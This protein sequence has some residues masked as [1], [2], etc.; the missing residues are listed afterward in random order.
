MTRRFE[1][2]M[3]KLVDTICWGRKFAAYS[4][5]SIRF[6]ELGIKQAMMDFDGSRI[7]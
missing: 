2:E 4:E 5:N 3:Q 1:S 7:E 6:C